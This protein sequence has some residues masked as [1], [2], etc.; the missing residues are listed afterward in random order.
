MA[1]KYI[2][3]A[4]FAVTGSLFY[5]S[6]SGNQS[7]SAKTEADLPQAAEPR[8]P[9]EKKPKAIVVGQKSVPI[10]SYASLLPTGEVK[11]VSGD[12]KPKDFYA[13]T[14]RP[15]IQ[16]CYVDLVQRR[17]AMAEGRKS[18]DVEVSFSGDINLVVTFDQGQIT[19]VQ[20]RSSEIRD[21]KFHSCLETRVKT[22][23][24]PP[25]LAEQ[26][27]WTYTQKIAYDARFKYFC[28]DYLTEKCY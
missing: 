18:G 15:T 25:H 28:E 7:N 13:T 5:L 9:S 12:E 10:K 4:S 6:K 27:A 20:S 3:L 11:N 24:F 8:L 23:T 19:S 21:S 26:A 17:R 16:S 2:L 1:L 14:V 22:W